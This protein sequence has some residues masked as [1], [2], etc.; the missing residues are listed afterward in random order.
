M[1]PQPPIV[2]VPSALA[3]AAEVVAPWSESPTEPEPGRLDVALEAADLLPVVTAL[4]AAGW[5]RLSAITGLDLKVP[6]VSS[7]PRAPGKPPGAAPAPPPTDDLE[8]LYHFCAGAAV[9][10]LRVCVGRANPV[11]PSIQGVLGYADF[12]ER[13]L[14]ELF[15]VELAGASSRDRL[16]LSD[17][18][19]ADVYPLRKDAVLPP[20]PGERG[21]PT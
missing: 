14:H 10:T 8:V 17:D 9:L 21:L 20:P 7:V 3:R 19:P 15:G 16:L 1:K 5:G 4:S 12:F 11:V 2:D 18:W 6:T 13:E